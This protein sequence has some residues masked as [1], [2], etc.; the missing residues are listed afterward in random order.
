MK[1]LRKRKAWIG[2]VVLM[3]L[4]AC[5][6]AT[7]NQAFGTLERDRVT[8][9]A[10]VSETITALPVQE[11]QQ[12]HIG[13]TIAQ[14]DTRSQQAQL[15]RAQAMQA[16]QQASLDRLLNGER[17]ED[18]QAAQANLADA[19]TH[20]TQAEKH[21]QRMTALYKQKLASQANFDDALAQRDSAR[22]TLK[23]AQQNWKKL[24]SGARPEDIAAAKAALGAAVAEV[25]VQR[26]A[27]DKL[28][29]RA[30]RNG[31][32]DSLPYELG[33][34]VAANSVLAVILT[35]SQPYARVYIPEPYLSRMTP[36]TP[37]TV[38][39]DGVHTPVTGVVR[40][41]SMQPAFTPYSSMSE[42]DRSRFVYLS[43][44]GLSA[45]ETELPAG[46]PVQVD[47]E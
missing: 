7:K 14:L 31:I 19:K 3:L 32:V 38:H 43:K 26:Y 46:I 28:T 36:G 21:Y 6:P 10:P 44:I 45:S 18:V 17:I 22:A 11:G 33:A 34:R 13:D 42:Q 23:A 37:V 9:T 25:A 8:L 2:T 12:V 30:S 41:L 5:S 35:D 47:L 39:I 15:Q 40:W 4:S 27:L 20:L 16:Q 1:S 24:A 29:I